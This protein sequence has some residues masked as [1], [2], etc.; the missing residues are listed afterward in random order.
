MGRGQQYSGSFV[1]RLRKALNLSD[2]ENRQEAIDNLTDVANAND[3]DVMTKDTATGK[4]IFKTPSAGTSGAMGPA[5]VYKI[6]GVGEYTEYAAS[7]DTTSA[8]GTAL[9]TALAAASSGETIYVRAGGYSTGGTNLMTDDVTLYCEPGVVITGYA[10]NG[11]FTDNGA[12][13]D[14]VI[15]GYGEFVASSTKAFF[16]Y[17]ANSTLHI[18][19]R[20]VESSGAYTIHSLGAGIGGITGIIDT[21]S[22]NNY[23]VVCQGGNYVKIWCRDITGTGAT[24]L[25]ATGS[26]TFEVHGAF[27]HSSGY[28]LYSGPGV[29]TIITNCRLETNHASRY[30]C[31]SPGTALGEV[32][33]I[34]CLCYTPNANTFDGNLSVLSCSNTD[35]T[36]VTTDSGTLTFMDSGA[37]GG[38]VPEYIYLQSYSQAEGDIHMSGSAEWDT[39]KMI[40]KEVRVWTTSTNWDLWLV[41]NDDGLVADTAEIPAIQL[42]GAGNGDETISV[43]RPYEDEDT[44]NE[45]HLNFDDTV[46]SA[47]FDVSVVATELA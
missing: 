21:I 23:A 17:H 7:A 1:N 15:S 38:G 41:Q 16:I 45:I 46:G 6:N 36:V 25:Y 9:V 29:E 39:S 3:E 12:Q 22:T 47:T 44:T 26:G 20:R 34:D 31:Y 10:S 14:M 2:V 33:L 27:M 8:R 5:N 28:V 18:T 24:V 42:M 11:L 40:I 37:G 4:A 13:M 35:G 19:A 32:K 30:C 43:N